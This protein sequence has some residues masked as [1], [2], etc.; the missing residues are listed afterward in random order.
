MT[1]R[2]RDLPVHGIGWSD[3][4]KGWSEAETTQQADHLIA[5]AKSLPHLRELAQYPLLLTLMAQV[6]SNIG[7]LPEN[8]ADLY[9]RAVNL[10][11]AHWDNRLVRDVGGACTVDKGIIMRLGIRLETLRAALERVAFSAPEKQETTEDRTDG[12]ADIALAAFS[13]I[14]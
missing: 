4:K 9:D 7:Y 13:R 12:C 5:A 3:P 2:S 8:R 6:H 1:I 11:L 10:L 14:V